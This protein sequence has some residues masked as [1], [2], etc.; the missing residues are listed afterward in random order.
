M[1]SL[2]RKRLGALVLFAEENVE[3]VSNTDCNMGGSIN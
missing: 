2:E 3:I 1:K